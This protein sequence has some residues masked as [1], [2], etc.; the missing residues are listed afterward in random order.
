VTGRRPLRRPGWSD[1]L[2]AFPDAWRVF[3]EAE[4]QLTE[5]R[6]RVDALERARPARPTTRTAV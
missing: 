3:A 6:L 5:I 1:R 4:H 2:L